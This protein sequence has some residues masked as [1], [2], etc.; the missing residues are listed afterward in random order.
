MPKF[1]FDKSLPHNIPLLPPDGAEPAAPQ[2]A[3]PALPQT[4]R[5]PPGSRR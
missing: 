2:S 4:G 3:G 1:T 5:H